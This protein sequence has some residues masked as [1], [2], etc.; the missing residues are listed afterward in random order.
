[1]ELIKSILPENGGARELC[2]A[3]EPFLSA[4]VGG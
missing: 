3:A 1:V 2:A 4:A